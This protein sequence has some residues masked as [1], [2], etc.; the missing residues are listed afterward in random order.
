MSQCVGCSGV[1][2]EGGQIRY[3]VVFKPTLVNLTE[4]RFIIWCL[5]ANIVEYLYS[6]NGHIS[7]ELCFN[8]LFFFALQN[9]V[10]GTL[11]VQLVGRCL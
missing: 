3:D 8:F 1:K 11:L 10:I 4:I 9:N 7:I 5:A 2:G 6:A